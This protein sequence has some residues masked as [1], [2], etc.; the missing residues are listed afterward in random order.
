ML[1]KYRDSDENPCGKSVKA[2]ECVCKNGTKYAPS[3]EYDIIIRE[4]IKISI[5]PSLALLENVEKKRLNTACVLTIRN[6]ILQLNWS[7][8]H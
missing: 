8:Q 6:S 1:E 4:N 2:K 7:R 3:I 5:V